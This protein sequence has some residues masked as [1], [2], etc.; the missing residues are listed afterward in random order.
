MPSVM[1]M[2]TAHKGD[3]RATILKKR[4]AT[5]AKCTTEAERKK[6]IKQYKRADQ[7]QARVFAAAGINPV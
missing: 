2:A 1:P 3:K 7:T 6:K 5:L 4:E